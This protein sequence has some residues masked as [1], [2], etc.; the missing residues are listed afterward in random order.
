M[1]Q[2]P[3]CYHMKTRE[4]GR[5]GYE[6]DKGKWSSKCRKEAGLCL[7]VEGTVRMG[8]SCKI[9]HGSHTRPSS[10]ATQ[11]QAL[12]S[13]S[14][15]HT[16]CGHRCLPASFTLLTLRHLRQAPHTYPDSQTLSLSRTD[17]Q[18]HS[19]RPTL[20]PLTPLSQTHTLTTH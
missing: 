18:I 8:M 3:R 13:C 2:E 5:G 1:T 16:A 14:P 20:V 15:E 7:A 6:R 11:A 9:L 17:L 10:P 19:L 4:S 12:S